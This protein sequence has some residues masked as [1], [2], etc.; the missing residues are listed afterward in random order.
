VLARLD[1]IARSARLQPSTSS[2]APA[3]SKS[4]GQHAAE[5]DGS[6]GW[7]YEDPQGVLGPKIEEAVRIRRLLERNTEVREV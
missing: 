5:S 3:A 7:W 1:R 4:S 2:P 6:G